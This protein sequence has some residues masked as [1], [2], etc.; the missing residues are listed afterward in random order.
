MTEQTPASAPRVP[1]TLDE[2]A[3]AAAAL[4]ADARTAGLPAPYALNCHDYGP[5]A[6]VLYLT[7]DE[8]PDIWLALNQWAAHYGTQVNTHVGFTPG[9]VH[10]TANFHRDGVAYEV[11]SVIHPRPE[12]SQ[13]DQQDAA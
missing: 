12:D 1:R 11:S 7:A 13:P 9:T 10:A 5:A 8:I 4:I 6:A 3:T 2:I